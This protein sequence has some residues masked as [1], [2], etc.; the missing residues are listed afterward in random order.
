M[1]KRLLGILF[2]F[3]IFTSSFS[4]ADAQ[5]ATPGGA[6]PQYGFALQALS[7]YLGRPVS[8]SSVTQWSYIV[9]IFN[10]AALGC[11]LV[12]SQPLASPL[13][14]YLF[15]IVIGSM[16]YDV[17]VSA[18]GA[19]AFPCVSPS[20]QPTTVPTAIPTAGTGAI[21]PGPCPAGF[22]G[23]LP[24][25]LNVG[26]E[27][28]VPAGNAPNRIR[29]FPALSGRQI[30]LIN[31]NTTA[32]II[33]G[34]SC[35]FNSGIIWWQIDYN[36]ITGWTAE[37]R[38]PDDYFLDPVG[39]VTPPVAS[40]FGE[41]GNSALPLE[42]SVITSGNAVNLTVLTA[43]PLADVSAIA[44]DPGGTQLALIADGA[45]QVFTLPDLAVN[46]S[47][48]V[49]ADGRRATAAIFLNPSTLLV[50]YDDG[51][52]ARLNLE[53]G[54]ASRLT[55]GAPFPIVSLSLSS[56]PRDATPQQLPANRVAV[57]ASPM[58]IEPGRSGPAA[59]VYIFD[60]NSGRLVVRV[61]SARL[62]DQAAYSPDGTLLAYSDG[63][64]H[65][66]DVAA[67]RELSNQAL[68]ATTY[69][70][71]LAWRPVS[72]PG[73][74][75]ADDILAFANGSGID[76][77][78]VRTGQRQ[79][80]LLDDDSRRPTAIAFSRD[81]TLLA[82][83]SD[84]SARGAAPFLPGRLTIFD[85]ATGDVLFDLDVDGL[86]AFAFSPDGTLL[87]FSDGEAVTLWGIR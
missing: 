69:Y 8:P 39:S 50:G 63:A 70:G 45:P 18:D 58:L 53:T 3:Y 16:T 62:I 21:T 76:V 42:R 81:G 4:R 6:P 79:R 64:L 28:R 48:S 38:L 10:D 54:A 73:T 52:L 2:I 27:A 87:A 55:E 74:T 47:L 30:G 20:A 22:S 36:G 51:R 60:L 77:L 26:A 32:R 86:R 65:L 44:F 31:P 1:S 9:Q 43:L 19:V 24:P 85:Y 46:E 34:P 56:T 29:E 72:D 57:A 25:R 68:D 13:Q 78:N 11:P 17:R 67:N 75:A 23:F 35:D 5:A 14:G 15:Q 61:D 7:E 80:Y 12:A 33:G 82:V 59:G 49:S 37:G 84:D 83:M 71:V 66:I 40:G 41:T